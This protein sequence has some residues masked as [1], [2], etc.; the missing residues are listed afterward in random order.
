MPTVA[1][2]YGMHGPNIQPLPAKL[3]GQIPAEWANNFEDAVGIE[4]EV[5]NAQLKEQPYAIWRAERDGSLRNSGMEFISSP[6]HAKDAPHALTNLLEK[7]L[8]G[9][10]CFSPRTS[11]HVH[12]DCTGLDSGK[13]LDIAVMYCAFEQ[14]FY[15]FVGRGRAKNIYCVPITESGLIVGAFRDTAK[16][17]IHSWSKYTGMNLLPIESIGTMEFRHMHGTFDIRKLCI[18]I[19]LL[20]KLRAWTVSVPTKKLRSMVNDFSPDTDYDTLLREIFGTDALYLKYQNYNDIKASVE[21]TRLAFVSAR[22]NA[23]STIGLEVD[24]HAPLFT[25]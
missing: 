23:V 16:S 4:V 11:V 2:V 17:V 13:V 10:C 18:W 21:A 9:D 7:A 19:R 15:R 3:T 8:S 5:E 1:E 6:I 12:F 24:N 22:T 20:C 14:L 25:I